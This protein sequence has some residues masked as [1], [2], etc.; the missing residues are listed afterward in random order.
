MSG[1]TQHICLAALILYENKDLLP[2]PQQRVS[3]TVTQHVSGFTQHICLA[4][5][6]LY[7]NKDLLPM[8]Q[9]RVS[10]TVTQ[11]VSG[12]T[13][14]ICLAALILYDNKDLLPMPQQRV[15]TTVTQHVSG[16]TQHIC[17][18]AHGKTQMGKGQIPCFLAAFHWPRSIGQI[19]PVD[20]PF[21]CNG[22]RCSG[23]LDRLACPKTAIQ[24]DPIWRMPQQRIDDVFLYE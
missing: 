10:T 17:L 23:G 6:I 8:P 12:F 19:D 4:A 22:T 21:P 3:T 20:P 14:H 9:P 24:I 18:A 16:F 13:Q 7:D 2:M 5:L 1:F 11:H 15:S